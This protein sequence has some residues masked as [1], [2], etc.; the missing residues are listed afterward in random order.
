MM[1]RDG[2]LFVDVIAPYTLIQVKH[3]KEDR[4]ETLEINLYE[5]LK[6]CGLVQDEKN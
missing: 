5:E 1:N 6:K 2:A 4:F 3:T